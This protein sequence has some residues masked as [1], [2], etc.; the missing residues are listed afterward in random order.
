MLLILLESWKN[1]IHAS[2]SWPLPP[3]ASPEAEE[4]PLSTGGGHFLCLTMSLNTHTVNH[5]LL[6]P[7]PTNHFLLHAI[8]G[9]ELTSLPLHPHRDILSFFYCWATLGFVPTYIHNSR[10]ACEIRMKAE[11]GP[12]FIFKQVEDWACLYDQQSGFT[13]PQIS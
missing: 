8:I 6:F 1:T 5:Y 12:R 10:K 7:P 2:S 13:H 11:G 3:T 4:V 9:N